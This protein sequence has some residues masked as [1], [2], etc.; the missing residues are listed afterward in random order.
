MSTFCK[1]RGKTIDSIPCYGK[2]ITLSKEY[3]AP[4]LETVQKSNIKVGQDCYHRYVKYRSM[5]I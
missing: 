3:N 4:D 5:K 1:T 2:T